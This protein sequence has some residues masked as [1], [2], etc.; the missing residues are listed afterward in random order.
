MNQLASLSVV[1]VILFGLVILALIEVAIIFFGLAVATRDI[2]RLHRSIDKAGGADEVAEALA[3]LNR[4]A[5][6]F[7]AD[8]TVSEKAGPL[9]LCHA[10]LEIHDQERGV[11]FT[12]LEPASAGAECVACHR[13][14]AIYRAK[15]Y[16]EEKRK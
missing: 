1:E 2:R 7:P 8:W 10:H 14:D 5:A 13:E 12:P 3:S 9:T 16:V 15:Y 11:S 6:V 4:A